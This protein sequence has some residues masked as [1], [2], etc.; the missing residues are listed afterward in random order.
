M[1]L[2][3][4]QDNGRLIAYSGQGMMVDYVIDGRQQV[5]V[6]AVNVK[7]LRS[8]LRALGCCHRLDVTRVKRVVVTEDVADA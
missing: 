5:V 4:K 3:T 1:K 6:V 2:E 8:V 7:A